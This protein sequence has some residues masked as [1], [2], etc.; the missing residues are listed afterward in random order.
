MSSVKHDSDEDE[1]GDEDE[2]AKA[3]R[4]RDDHGDAGTRTACSVDAT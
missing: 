1:V 4:N 3:G 2:T